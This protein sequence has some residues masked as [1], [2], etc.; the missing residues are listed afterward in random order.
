MKK[1]STPRR[2]RPPHPPRTPIAFWLKSKGKTREWLEGKL[3]ISQGW[4]SKIVLGHGAPSLELAK[5]IQ[6]VT[7]GAVKADSW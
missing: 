6:A 3:N 2:G 5:R 4:M 7:K 1:K